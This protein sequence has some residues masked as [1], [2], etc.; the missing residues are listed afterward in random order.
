MDPLLFIGGPGGLVYI[1]VKLGKLRR[2]AP[3]PSPNRPNS[4]NAGRAIA[5]NVDQ[6]T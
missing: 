5:P 6:S 3:R 1:I 2:M 4:V